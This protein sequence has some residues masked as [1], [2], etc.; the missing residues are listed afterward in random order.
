MKNFIR[1]SIALVVFL[2][3]VVLVPAM[4]LPTQGF[5]WQ[6]YA[7][8]YDLASL[9][10]NHASGAPGSFFTIMGTNFSPE[11]TVSVFANDVLLGEVDTSE[12]GDLLFLLDSTG[13]GDGYYIVE[14][15]GNESAQTRV[16]VDTDD[17]LWTQ[18][19]EGTVFNLA[20][21]GATPVELLFMPLIER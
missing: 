4:G 6:R 7:G 11:T 14:V 3:G 2:S 8:V 5:S 19:D 16:L 9:D 1:I 17:T 13:A 18:E 21:Q 12:S 20:A 10:V 15:S